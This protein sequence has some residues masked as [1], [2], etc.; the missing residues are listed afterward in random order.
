M[1]AKLNVLCGSL[2]VLAMMAHADI[3][4]VQITFKV[5][6]ESGNP[7]P[8]VRLGAS[9]IQSK[10]IAPVTA[11]DLSKKQINATTDIHGEAVIKASS[12][13]DRHVGYRIDPVHGYYRVYGGDYTFQQVVNGEWRPQN[14]II[15]ITLR[16]ILHPIPMYAKMPENLELPEIENPIGYDLVVGDWVMPYG[17]GLKSDLVFR[18]DRK[19]D[20]TVKIGYYQSEVKLF[21]TTLTV[22]FANPD[23]GIQSIATND[24]YAG[25][26]TLP[27]YAPLDG[28]EPRLVEHTYRESGEKPIITDVKQGQAY[29]YRVRIVKQDGKIVS[30]QY[31]K[32]KG[33]NFDVINSPTAIITFTYYLNPTPNDRNME[34]DPKQNLFKNLTEFEQVLSP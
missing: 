10:L 26:F 22:S 16:P 18:L 29:F 31:G 11:G 12:V 15:D 9:F 3:G 28:Y 17:K 4:N 6:D 7:V 14:P 8:Q 23:D 20:K 33:I 24:R 32:I 27:R 19:P 25:D 1:K 13:Y 34:F 5:T 30:A 2:L 21:D